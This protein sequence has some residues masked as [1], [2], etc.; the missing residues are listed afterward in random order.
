MSFAVQLAERATRHA[1]FVGLA[2]LALAATL[3]NPAFANPGN[4]ANLVVQ[5]GVLALLA[6]GQTLV[7]TAGLID[8]SVGTAV[9]SQHHLE[10]RAV[11]GRVA[12]VAMCP[13]I[14]AAKVD[15]DVT[16]QERAIA[17]REHRALKV[18]TCAA[19]APPGV[20]HPQLPA[21]AIY[22]RPRGEPLP[23]P[24][25]RQQRFTRSH[26]RSRPAR[27]SG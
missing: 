8:L 3:L 9:D 11:V 26:T 12:M 6:I 10:H 14:G 19:P 7:I 17:E 23:L 25:R 24:D 27:R 4:L 16:T 22:Q 18:R 20:D 13:P 1:I 5:S 15:L 21:E 2:A